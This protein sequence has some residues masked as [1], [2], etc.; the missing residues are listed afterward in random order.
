MKLFAVDGLFSSSK[1]HLIKQV[2]EEHP[3]PYL[4]LSEGNPDLF[5]DLHYFF[6]AEPLELIG[7]EASLDI[8]GLR[9]RVVKEFSEKSD[10]APLVVTLKALFDPLP[11]PKALHETT[12]KIHKK[13]PF[14]SFL[15]Q[16]ESMGFS[17]KKIV[18][19]KGDYALRGGLIDIFPID[20]MEPVRI[21]FDGD[22]I[23][24]LR[25]FDPISQRSTANVEQYSFLPTR[26]ECITQLLDLFPTPFRIFLDHPT[27]LEDR[28]VQL[29]VELA[30]LL[31]R[32]AELYF[33]FDEPIESLID[34]ERK[35]VGRDFYT[36]K[37]GDLVE[38]DLFKSTYKLKIHFSPYAPVEAHLDVHKIGHQLHQAPLTSMQVHLLASSAVEETF[39]KKEL[40][41]RPKNVTIEMGYLSSGFFFDRELFLPYTEFSRR[42]KIHRKRWRI[43]NHVPVS[44]F[45][46]LEPGDLVVHYHNGVGKFLGFER[47]QNHQNEQDDFIVLEYANQSK[48]YVPMSQAHL[49]S[50]YIGAKEDTKIALN[51]LGTNSWA[52]A[53]LKVEKAIVGYARE[54][55]HRQAMRQIRGGF[56]YPHDSTE[57]ELFEDAFEF[58]ETIDQM[59]AIQDIK[60]DMCSNEG[61]DRLILGDV[62]YGKTEIAMRAAAKAVLD[63]NKQVAVLVPTTVLAV[64]HYENFKARM[65]GF[66]IEIDLACRF[67]TSKEIKA[68]IERVGEGK[69]DILI[70]THRIISKD[71]HFKDLGLIIVDE[72]QRFGVRAK[73]W[74]KLAT[75]GVDCLTLSATPIPRTLHLSLV[76]ARKMSVISSPP[77]D[78]LPVKIAVVEDHDDVIRDGLLEEF[79]RGGQ[80]YFLY[81]RVETIHEMKDRLQK[82]VPQA[83]IGVVHGQMEPDEIDE[84]FHGFKSGMIDLLLATTIIENGI[85]I[86]NANT[87][88][89]HRADTFGISDLY[90][91]KGRV[92]RSDKSAYA[93]FMVPKGQ[94]LREQSQQRIRAIV[95]ASG[96][97]G[98]L[99]VAMRDLEIRGAGDILGV[100][101]SGHVA[102]VGFHLYCKLLKRTIDLMRA[103]KQASFTETK[104]EIP[105][106][107]KLPF[108]YIE[109]KSIRMEL[110]HRFG[111]CLEPHEVHE[112]YKEIIDRFGPAPIE[113]K[114]LYMVAWIRTECSQYGITQVRLKNCTLSIE[115]EKRVQSFLA[116]P[117]KTPTEFKDFVLLKIALEPKFHLRNI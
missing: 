92:G 78:R 20:A 89:V 70:G 54:L 38:I 43:H 24:S 117:F 112:L 75:V 49:V 87:I 7:H 40:P 19:D 98:G 63:G 100:Q 99:K 102:S 72:E 6:K 113:V 9:Y 59:K 68:T 23:I 95:E 65:E 111:E 74:L 14:D 73:E 2:Q 76:N 31:N 55:L 11:D 44:E 107:A 50:R 42:K 41:D 97:G 82:L 4:I 27:H 35:P 28:M 88:F 33:L 18:V 109:E 21:E 58:D 36:R 60:T 101:Q 77:S 85:D 29:K 39:F 90:Q 71:V 26:T 12:L 83:K 15:F 62:G 52:K 79:Q 37:K 16:L 5:H 93:Y 10:A 1:A 30:P 47:M 3:L 115:S 45:H 91:L 46:E 34:E 114:W 53:K 110:Y 8:E 105:F 104:V 61:M 84:I 81:N 108:F 116:P 80:A 67:R 66:A 32:A 94:S 13:V 69:V 64:Q 106:E 96:Y 57:M 103:N 48:L 17:R 51:T 86:P 25:H 56:Q 22:E